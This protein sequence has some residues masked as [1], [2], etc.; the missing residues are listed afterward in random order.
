MF[1]DGEGKVKE[2][3]WPRLA[4]FTKGALI[5]LKGMHDIG[6]THRD[7]KPENFLLMKIP[8]GSGFIFVYTTVDGRSCWIVLG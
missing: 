4:M 8:T 3:A 7:I 2:D 1:Q 5:V 6:L